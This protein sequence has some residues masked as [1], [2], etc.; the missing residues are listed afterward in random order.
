MHCTESDGDKTGNAVPGL[1]ILVNSELRSH[2]LSLADM[3]LGT[4]R[5]QSSSSKTKEMKS[6][7]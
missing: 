6:P 5:A 7:M 1:E 4:P 2:A 3:M